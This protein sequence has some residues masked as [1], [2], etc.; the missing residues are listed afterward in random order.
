MRGPR[1]P[2]RE[3]RMSAAISARA[4]LSQEGRE[5]WASL[6]AE[7]ERQAAAM[8]AV[9][10]GGVETEPLIECRSGKDLQ[11]RKS[12]YPSTSVKVSIDYC[13]WGPMIDGVITGYQDE[14]QEF[15]PEEFTVPIAR[16][17]DGSVIA[18]YEE[19]RSFS[20]R[21][22]ASYLMQSFRRCFPGVSLPCD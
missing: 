6:T 14:A 3:E 15:C 10:S 11:I 18:I 9:V 1:R 16:D 7:C 22:L 21:D 5:Y 19:G 13:S 4:P 12:G 20:A 8:N 2:H 17:L